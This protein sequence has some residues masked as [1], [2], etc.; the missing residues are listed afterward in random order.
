MRISSRLKYCKKA[1]LVSRTAAMVQEVPA[2]RPARV[3]VGGA[4]TLPLA[5]GMGAPCGS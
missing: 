1:L 3:S 5:F 4:A 2:V